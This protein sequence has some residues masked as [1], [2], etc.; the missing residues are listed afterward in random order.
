MLPNSRKKR[1]IPAVIPAETRMYRESAFFS[2]F[3]RR[4]LSRAIRARIGMAISATIRMEET[5]RNLL[6]SGK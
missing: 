3:P 1:Q 2:T 6:Y 4:I 5:D